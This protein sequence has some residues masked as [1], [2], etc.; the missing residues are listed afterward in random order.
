MRLSRAQAASV[1][2]WLQTH[3]LEAIRSGS[4]AFILSAWSR[5]YAVDSRFKWIDA[6]AAKLW[7]CHALI[8]GGAIPPSA[9]TIAVF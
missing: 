4:G 3:A 9:T 7:K 6:H 2:S 5:P 8:P 1:E